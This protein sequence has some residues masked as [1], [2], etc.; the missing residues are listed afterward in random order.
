M[1]ASATPVTATQ[2]VLVT[3]GGPAPQTGSQVLVAV[4]A[5]LNAAG[6]GAVMAGAV[7]SIGPNS[8]ISNEINSA[9]PVSTVDNADTESGQI[10][11]VQALKDLLDSKP[12]AK[13]GVDPGTAPSPAPTPSATATG[14][15]GG[16]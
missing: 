12:P 8:V 11:V 15:A 6:S 7:Q 3:P 4:T 14:T 16:H 5:Q 2:A 9:H 1:S 13:Y 10:M